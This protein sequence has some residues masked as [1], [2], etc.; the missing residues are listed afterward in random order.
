MTL[1]GVFSSWETSLLSCLRSSRWVSGAEVIWLKAALIR[2]NSSDE[3]TG[4]RAVSPWAIAWVASVRAVTGAVIRL[5]IHAAGRMPAPVVS[6]PPI[7]L[8]VRIVF[9]KPRDSVERKS[10]FTSR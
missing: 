5:D 10:W 8:T 2:P 4:S 7:R 1:S 3:V 9:R 6:K